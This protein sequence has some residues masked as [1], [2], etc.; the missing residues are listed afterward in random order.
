MGKEKKKK[1]QPM[2][3]EAITTKF[4]GSNAT[5]GEVYLIHHYGRSIVFSGYSRLPPPIKLTAMI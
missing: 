3:Q 2:I 5:H 1:R 4:V